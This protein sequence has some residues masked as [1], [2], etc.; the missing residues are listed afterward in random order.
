LDRQ[1]ANEEI[2]KQ[3]FS[4]WKN[5]HS[6]VY[7]SQ[8]EENFRFSVFQDALKKIEDLNAKSHGAQYGLNKY[9]DWTP[10][11]FSKLRGYKPRPDAERKTEVLPKGP[12]AAPATYDWRTLDRVTPVKDQGQCGSC[13]AFSA[14][15]NVESIYMINKKIGSASMSPLSPQQVVDCDTTDSGCNGGDTPTAYAYIMSAGG[16][17]T[18]ADYPYTAADGTC[19]FDQSKV[20]VSITNWKYATQTQSESE[21]VDA[22][23]NWGPLSI[24]VDASS[25]Q[26]YTSGIVMGA[27]C[28][29]NLDHCVQIVGYDTSASTPFWIVR[30]SWG[31]DWGESGFIRLQYGQDTCGVADEATSACITC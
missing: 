10:E 21:M 22:T 12:I 25:W 16:M 27:D 3:L 17:E 23:V 14:T 31:A 5:H 7:S 29:N 11:E 9:T 30:N 24:C 13:W 1:H 8:E 26:Y 4:V 28:T 18:D 20:K 2:Q 15:E 19:A 6:K